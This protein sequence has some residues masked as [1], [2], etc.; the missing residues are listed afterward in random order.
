MRVGNERPAAE[1]FEP[2]STKVADHDAAELRDEL[3]RRRERAAGGEHVVDEET[4]IPSRMSSC[5]SI[6]AVPYSSE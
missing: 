3:V 4:R 1:G 2:I 5:A 6:V